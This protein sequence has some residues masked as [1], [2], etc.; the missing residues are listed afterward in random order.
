MEVAILGNNQNYRRM[1]KNSLCSLEEVSF[2][3]I[4]FYSLEDTVKT[5][6]W[7]NHNLLFV[8][9]DSEEALKTVQHMF[10]LGTNFPPAIIVST[11]L[12]YALKCAT[13]NVVYYLSF[14]AEEKHLKHALEKS[15]CRR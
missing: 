11:H 3:C 2:K 8:I 14:P 9:I 13:L 7:K 12:E 5:L 15:L 4:K 1:L 10:S 6:D